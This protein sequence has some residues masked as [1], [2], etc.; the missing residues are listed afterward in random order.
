MTR[1]ELERLVGDAERQ[2]QLRHNLSHCRSW[3][4]LLRAANR[5]GYAVEPGDLRQALREDHAGSF[6]ERSRLRPIPDLL[7]GGPAD[8]SR[9]RRSA[10]TAR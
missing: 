4:D 2:P 3:Q 5:Q 9:W 1:T 7:L 10:S 6:L 8:Q